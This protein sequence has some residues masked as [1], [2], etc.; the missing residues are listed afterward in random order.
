MHFNVAD[1]F[2]SISKILILK[3]H[4][5]FFRF[6]SLL[7][8]MTAI[9]EA[10]SGLSF[11]S[12]VHLL[13]CQTFL[14]HLSIQG[15]SFWFRLSG[16]RSMRFVFASSQYLWIKIT[17]IWSTYPCDWYISYRTYKTVKLQ[18]N[19]F[20]HTVEKMQ[21]CIGKCFTIAETY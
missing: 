4:A 14:C 10:N 1:S 5:F 15:F 13:H 6:K 3:F 7:Q 16:V 2:F 9:L 21:L 19:T 11:S 17:V 8:F 12:F 20:L 18:K